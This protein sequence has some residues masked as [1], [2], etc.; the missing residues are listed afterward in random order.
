MPDAPV[1][2]IGTYRMP[3]DAVLF[4]RQ[5]SQMTDFVAAN[6]PGALA[7]ATYVDSE[8]SEVAT[9]M[10]HR[11]ATSLL[12]HFEVAAELIEQ[13]SRMVQMVGINVYGTL[14]PAVVDGL[15]R[16][17]KGWPVDIKEPIRGFT[18]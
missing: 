6:E 17:S 4:E 18:R 3:P 8:R 13:G 11:D 2:L 10:V 16:E 1:L 14:P 7:F 15:R 5:S 12:H 9:V